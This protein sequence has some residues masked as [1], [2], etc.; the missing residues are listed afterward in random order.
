MEARP[1]V[2]QRAV[3]GITML[4]AAAVTGQFVAGKALRDTLF[5]TSLDVTALPAMLIATSAVSL[6]LVSANSRCGRLVPPSVLVPTSF[7]VSGALFLVEW[8]LRPAAPT[9]SAIILYLH[10]SAA[11]PI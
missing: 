9:A 1:I 11:G 4:C 8:I 6:A 3:L 2:N 5:L 10:I 7:M